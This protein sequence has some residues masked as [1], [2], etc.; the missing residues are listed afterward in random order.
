VI[1][2][3]LVDAAEDIALRR[4]KVGVED[5][6]VQVRRPLPPLDRQALLGH[7]RREVP[8]DVAE[9]VGIAL[10]PVGARVVAQVV[11]GDPGVLDIGRRV[12]RVVG[13]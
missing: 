7:D 6:P 9:P 10:A 5:G 2:Q 12:V 11:A 13:R 1:V 4:L 3:C 8:D